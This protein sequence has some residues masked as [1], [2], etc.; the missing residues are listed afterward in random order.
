MTNVAPG[1]KRRHVNSRHLDARGA[2]EHDPTMAQGSDPARTL[3]VLAP[4][5]KGDVMRT[6]MRT[7]TGRLY[8]TMTEAGERLLS[9]VVPGVQAGGCYAGAGLICACSQTPNDYCYTLSPPQW[10]YW[11]LSCLGDCEARSG[12]LSQCHPQV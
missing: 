1:D 12:C 5:Q 9:T 3:N 7:M 6:V 8:E 11:I 4:E 2:E 10:N